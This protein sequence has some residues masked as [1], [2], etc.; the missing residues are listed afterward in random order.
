M[1]RSFS[2]ILSTIVVTAIISGCATTKPIQEV[3][4]P[5]WVIKGSGAFDSKNTRV[6]HG[7]GFAS[8]VNNPSLLRTTS[9]NRARNEIAKIFKVY[10]SSLMKDY[11]A[12]TQDLK[13]NSSSEEQHIEQV[14]KTITSET[15]TGVEIIDYWQDPNTGELFALAKLDLDAFENLI[16]QTNQLNG[17]SKEYIRNHAS[18]LHEELSKEVDKLHN[19]ILDKFKFP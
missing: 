14:V 9:E 19:Y 1:K 17:K 11:V 6:F 3:E 5:K 15:L 18:L 16:N 2:L 10:V 7:V 8:G 4:A 12:S 13:A